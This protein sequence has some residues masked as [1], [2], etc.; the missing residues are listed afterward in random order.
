MAYQTTAKCPVCQKT[1]DTL[2]H[3]EPEISG[4]AEAYCVWM[5]GGNMPGSLRSAWAPT[6]GI[7]AGT[8]IP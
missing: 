3:D 2:K 1:M 4:M 7:V 8:C 6:V 5:D